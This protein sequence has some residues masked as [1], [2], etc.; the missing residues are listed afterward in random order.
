MKGCLRWLFERMARWLAPFQKRRR[1]RRAEGGSSS[2]PK[3]IYP[4]W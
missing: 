1:A 2:P 4:L 3:D